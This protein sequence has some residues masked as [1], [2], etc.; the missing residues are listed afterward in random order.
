[1]SH[2]EFLRKAIDEDVATVKQV[3]RDPTQATTLTDQE[4]AMLAFVEKMTKASWTMTRADVEGLRTAGFSDVQILEI[5]QL[6]AWFNFMTRV[7]DA[8]GVEV[9]DW[10]G[11]WRQELLPDTA[12][13]EA[14]R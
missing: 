2:G 13:V 5:V 4:Q 1:V 3:Q 11:A 8:L 10:R 9:E 12:S 7:A 6:T 14:T